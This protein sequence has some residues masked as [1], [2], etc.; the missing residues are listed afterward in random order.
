VGNAI[1]GKSLLLDFGDIAPQ[2]AKMGRWLMQTT[3]AGRFTQFNASFVHADSLGGAVTSLIK[4]IVTHKL[5]RDVRVDLPG[6]DDVDDF[7]AEQGDGYRVYDS[8]G[9]DNPVR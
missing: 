2:S 8:Q 3:L 5:V 9:G 6:Q 4:E 1:A 7:L